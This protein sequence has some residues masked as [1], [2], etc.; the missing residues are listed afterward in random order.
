LRPW[1]LDIRH[2][3]REA[4]R[5]CIEDQ[6]RAVAILQIGWMD[7]DVQQEAER[8]DQDVPLAARDLLARIEPCGSSARPP[9][10]QPW[11]FGCR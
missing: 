9:F 2:R 6:S 10:A 5:A 4:P 1:R 11:R 8:V 3:R 7:D